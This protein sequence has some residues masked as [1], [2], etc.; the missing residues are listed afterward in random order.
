MT[1]RGALSGNLAS[2]ME[3]TI[4]SSSSKRCGAPVRDYDS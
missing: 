4:F 3:T 1:G 2:T